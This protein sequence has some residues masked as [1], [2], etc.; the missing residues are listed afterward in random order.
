MGTNFY[1]RTAATLL[2]T[3]EDVPEDSDDP[4]IHIGKRSAAGP[5]CWDCDQTLCKD[6]IDGIH[7]GKSGWYPACPRC[8]K[9][10]LKEPSLARGA[11]AIE[12]GFA[13]PEVRRP[14]G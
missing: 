13:K 6:G 11:A 2:P 12:L 5:Y 10:P 4:R 3:G 9:E 1:W 7:Q 14:T 8:G